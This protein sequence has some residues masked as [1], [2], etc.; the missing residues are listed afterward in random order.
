MV[1]ALL[2]ARVM[3][4][5]RIAALATALLLLGSSARAAD[6]DS[7]G[8]GCAAYRAE[9]LRARQQLERGERAAAIATLRRAKV[10]LRECGNEPPPAARS[11]ENPIA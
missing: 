7:Q 5:A 8:H 6:N 10:A 2:E 1:R 4:R 3:R 11:G 9:L